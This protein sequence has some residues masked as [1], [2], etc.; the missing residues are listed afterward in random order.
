MIT[1][2]EFKKA[3]NDKLQAAFPELKIYGNDTTDGYVRPSFFTEVIPHP[4]SY[5]TKNY[6]EGGATFKATLFEN[7][8]DEAYCLDVFDKVRETFGMNLPVRTRCLFMG[9]ISFEFIGEYS[10][11]LQISIEYDWLEQVERSE[12]EEIM[13]TVELSVEK[14]GE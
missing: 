9:D 6:T 13:E 5:N 8:H 4:Y 11:M 1:M 3:C 12:P 14:K 10:N 7:T 2:R